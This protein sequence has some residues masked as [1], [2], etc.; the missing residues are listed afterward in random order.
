MRDWESMDWVLFILFGVGGGAFLVGTG[1]AAV[2]SGL[3][4]LAASWCAACG[5]CGA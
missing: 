1:V 2:L 3:G 5:N 4:I